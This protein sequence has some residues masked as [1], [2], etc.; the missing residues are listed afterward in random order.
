MKDTE[1]RVTFVMDKTLWRLVQLISARLMYCDEKGEIKPASGSVTI[2]ELLNEW[3][4]EMSTEWFPVLLREFRTR[5]ITSGVT[6]YIEESIKL[7]HESAKLNSAPNIKLEDLTPE[8]LRIR[9]E[10]LQELVDLKE[11]M[12]KA[13]FTQAEY[14][15]I[16][17]EK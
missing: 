17:G 5:N 2:R 16:L 11:R 9:K 7:Y 1:T 14:E 8:Q 13:G 4:G 12:L 3:I 15:K 10:S 6:N